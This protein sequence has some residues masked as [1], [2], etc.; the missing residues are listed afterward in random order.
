MTVLA[1]MGSEGVLRTQSAYNFNNPRLLHVDY[2]HAVHQLPHWQ[3]RLCPHLNLD[4]TV[5]R[6]TL[7]QHPLK[8]I[9]NTFGCALL[10]QDFEAVA[11]SLL[12]RTR[13]VEGDGI[14]VLMLK[15]MT[16]LGQLYTMTMV[17]L[18]LSACGDG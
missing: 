17:R 1:S 4:K 18:V 6:D 16:S 8:I 12:A 15:T 14:V 5:R 9:G 2:P 11:P 10:L 7:V 3:R 13:D